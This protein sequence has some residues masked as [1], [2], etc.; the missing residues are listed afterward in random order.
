MRLRGIASILPAT[1]PGKLV[2][3]LMLVALAVGGDLAA[4]FILGPGGNQNGSRV[5]SGYTGSGHYGGVP[6]PTAGAGLPIIV[7]GIGAYGAY[8]LVRRHRR[9]SD[10]A[11]GPR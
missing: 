6:S 7:P 5:T 10:A 9:R 11:L 2:L 3:A 4:G 8:W 1:L